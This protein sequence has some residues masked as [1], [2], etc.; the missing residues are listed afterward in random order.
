MKKTI[1]GYVTYRAPRFEWETEKW[2]F[3]DFKPTNFNAW[4]VM[5]KPYS[6]EVE[7]PDDY[8][9]RPQMVAELEAEKTRIRAEFAAKVK[10]LDDRI[11]SLLAIEMA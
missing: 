7:V 5:V 4:G 1:E 8:D 6:F 2:G 10:E 11:Q 3:V 9:P